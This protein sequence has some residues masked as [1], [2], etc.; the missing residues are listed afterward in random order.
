MLVMFYGTTYGARLVRVEITLNGEVILEGNASD[1]GERDA[2]AI[3]EALKVT[4]L[5]ET[6]A[7]RK[8]KIDPELKEY[9][10]DLDPPEKGHAWP[11][12]IDASFGGEKETR[13]V[14]IKRVTPD[15]NGGSWRID[16]QD[17]DDAFDTRM[18]MRSEA[19]R[20]KRPKY[21]KTEAMVKEKARLRQ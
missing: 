1:N 2:D 16:S 21:D 19:V 9:Q 15:Q 8:L 12:K 11:I 17:L 18:I 20:L 3:W 6:D 7:F 13:F 10:F 4:N 14:T 5:R